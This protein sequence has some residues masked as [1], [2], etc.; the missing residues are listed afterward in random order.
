MR[1]FCGVLVFL[2]TLT[3]L[4]CQPGSPALAA[5]PRQSSQLTALDPAACPPEG[6]AAGQRLSFRVAFEIGDYALAAGEDDYNVAVCFYIP[7]DWY[8]AGSISLDAQGA[9]THQTYVPFSSQTCAPD[10]AP[11]AGYTLAAG[12]QAAMMENYFT[13]N[14]D[15]RL[16]IAPDAVTPGSMLARVFERDASN[17]WQRSLQLFTPQT[18]VVPPAASAYIASDAS[19]CTGSPCYLNSSGDEPGGIGTAL[20]DA[21]DAS[22]AD[23]VIQVNGTLPVKGQMVEINKPIRLVGAGQSRLTTLAGAPCSATAPLLRFSAGGSLENLNLDDGDCTGAFDRPLVLIDSAEPVNILGNTLTGASDAIRVSGAG[24]GKVNV[25]FN[26]ISGNSGYAL[27]WDNT[28]A[29]SL[30]MSANNLHANRGGMAVECSLGAKAPAGN[31]VVDHNYWGAEAPDASSHCALNPAK[32]LGAPVI[33]NSDG[34]GVQAKRL[35]VSEQP[36]AA[37]NGEITYMRIGGS[38]FDIYL[39]N[40]G[41]E[42]P[43]S[44]PFAETALNAPLPCS[45]A[46]D[47]FLSDPAPAGTTLDL[48][49]SYAGSQACMA[50]VEMSA[51][52]EQSSAP[53]AYPLYWY[54]PG[55]T[56]TTGWNGQKPNGSAAGGANG[57]NTQCDLTNHAIKVS[58]DEDGRPGLNSDLNFTP[59]LVGIPMPRTFNAFASDQTNTVFWTTFAEP[60]V[61]GFRLLRSLNPN[62]P[63]EPVS[64]LIQR[65]GSATSGMTYNFADGG[66]TNGVTN[67]YR[68]QTIR[69]SG[70]SIFSQVISIVPNVATPTPT[71]T[72]APTSTPWPTVTPYSFPTSIYTF[73]TR[74]NAAFHDRDPSRLRHKTTRYPDRCCLAFRSNRDRHAGNIRHVDGHT[75]RGHTRHHA[76]LHTDLAAHTVSQPADQGRQPLH[77]ASDG[78]PLIGGPGRRFDLAA[79]P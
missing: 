2:L 29:A 33:L 71:W 79:F 72:R 17:V 68:L 62:G 64:D 50:A 47:V 53:E 69:S 65:R 67:Y 15:L 25:Q 56:V 48:T 44:Q 3:V 59:F 58:I 78:H 27:F 77:L 60:D 45:N 40:H 66:R 24:E 11:P 38:D 39:V 34:P 10:S 32:R 19:Q 9:T 7:A 51:F 41:G 14:L 63:F 36:Q 49:F 37:F 74:A 1:R 5:P 23:S 54:D 43:T 52:C 57:Q 20:K 75:N 12:G 16:R 55:G 46:W 6:C 4:I 61:S 18:S 42:Y 13:D 35:T 31:R 8:D 21:V 28:S 22:P 73:P 70:D 30:H 76:Y 26:Q